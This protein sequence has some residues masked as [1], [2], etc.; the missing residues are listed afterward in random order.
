MKRRPDRGVVYS[1]EHGRMCPHCGRKADA[2]AWVFAADVKPLRDVEDSIRESRVDS[3]AVVRHGKPPHGFSLL[4]AD[5]NLRTF[6]SAEFD[7]VVHEVS[8]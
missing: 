6:D 2:C 1:S 4:G 3:D 7:G 5:A 8:K